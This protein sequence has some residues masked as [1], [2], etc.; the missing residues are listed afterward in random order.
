ML[1]NKLNLELKNAEPFIT[2]DEIYEMQPMVNLV[3]DMLRNKS[4]AGNDYLGWVD[5][6]LDLDIDEM[7]RI[8]DAAL[9]IRKSCEVFIIIGIGGS[10]LGAR[11]AIEMLTHNFHNIINTGHPKILYVGNNI[12]STYISELLEVIEDKDICL[13]VISK[14]GTTTEPA[15]AF[16]ILKDFME[17]RYGRNGAR[18]RIFTTTDK[19]RGALKA[20]SDAEGYESFVI[21]DDIG[22]RYSVLTAVGLLPIAAAGIDIDSILAGAR[23]AALDLNCSELTKNSAYKYAVIRNILY[24]K[25]KS[26]ELLANFEPCMHYFG[27]WFKQLFAESE[28]KGGNGIFPSIADFSTDLHSIGQYIQDGKRLIFETFINIEKPKKEIEIISDEMDLDGLNFLSGKS[29]D[30][31]RELAYEGT[32]LAHNQG[33]VP[34]ITINLPEISTYHYGYMVYFFEMACAA[35]GYILG[36]NP[37]D[38]P[39]V[40]AYKNHMHN[41]MNNKG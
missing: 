17:K 9:R 41:L 12:S 38:Q 3:H 33:D 36:V 23:D 7:N 32:K 40:E 21:P 22:G 31:V 29:I 30:F 34:V 13:N 1:T 18:D 11:S 25:G 6:P 20:M 39:G 28:G 2:E 35:S 8:K 26:I 24:K 15:I 10:Y 4:G 27:E 5:L 14:S 16:R 37:F 19:A